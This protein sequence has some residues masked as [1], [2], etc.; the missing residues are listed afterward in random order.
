MTPDLYVFYFYKLLGGSWEG[1]DAQIEKLSFRI[2]ATIQG[3]IYYTTFGFI[4]NQ[5]HKSKK[6]QSRDFKFRYLK[7]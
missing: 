7:V 4:T 1:E 6:F 3:K 5:D 2:E